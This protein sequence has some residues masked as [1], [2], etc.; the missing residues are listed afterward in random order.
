MKKI[1]HHLKMN[2]KLNKNTNPTKKIKRFCK[3]KTLMRTIK[4]KLLRDNHLNVKKN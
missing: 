3:I 4:H 1:E 2:K